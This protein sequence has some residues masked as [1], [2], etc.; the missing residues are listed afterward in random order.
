VLKATTAATRRALIKFG[1]YVRSTARQSIRSR[2]AASAAGSPPSSHA[3]TLKR[4]IFFAYEPA[5]QNV[6]IGP[7]LVRATPGPSTIPEAL[8]HG[9]ET[10]RRIL[11]GRSRGLARRQTVA[12]R[13][14]MQ[15]AFEKEQTKLPALWADSIKK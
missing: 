6:V 7:E 4:L 13:P 10:T 3:G 8:E 1:S 5:S 9:G 11:K 12:A 15:P 14:F 2:K